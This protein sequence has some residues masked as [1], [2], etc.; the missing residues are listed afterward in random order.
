MAGALGGSHEHVHIG[1]GLDL[2]I[3]DIE[4]VG[5]RQGLA[6][7]EVGGDVLL[8]HIG[9]G[10]VIDEDHDDVGSLGRLGH[11]DHLEPVLLRHGPGLAALAQADDDVTAGV[12]EILS[13]GVTLRAVADDGNLLAV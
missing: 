5:K 1:G 13:V 8:I 10:L 6:S 4:T 12:P 2:L 9:L 7:G 11:G 3:P